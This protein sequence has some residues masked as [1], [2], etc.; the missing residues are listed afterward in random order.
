METVLQAECTRAKPVPDC[1]VHSVHW[2]NIKMY[3]LFYLVWL[4][5]TPDVPFYA[6]IHLVHAYGT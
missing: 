4:L 2:D 5:T 1:A 6:G 3:S